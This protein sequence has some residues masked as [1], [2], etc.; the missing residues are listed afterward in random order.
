M[1]SHLILN[2]ALVVGLSVAGVAAQ[3]GAPIDPVTAEDTA[4]KQAARSAQGKLIRGNEL[5][6]APIFDAADEVC[7]E[8]SDALIGSE[9]HVRALLLSVYGVE[10]SLVITPVDIVTPAVE[11]VSDPAVT[12]EIET[13]TMELSSVRDLEELVLTIDAELLRAAPRLNTESRDAPITADRVAAA[14]E[15]FGL[16]VPDALAVTLQPSSDLSPD[17]DTELRMEDTAAELEPA[18]PFCRASKLFGARVSNAEGEDLGELGNLA[19]S[20]GDDRVAYAVLDFGGLLGLGD[21]QFAVPFAALQ[22]HAT[23]A[24]LMLLEVS[25][26]Q[27]EESDGFEQWPAAPD[28]EL[29]PASP[30]ALQ[31]KDV[32]FGERNARR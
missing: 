17:E 24:E 28:T 4:L 29:F 12:D 25:V 26:A 8:V 11:P 3:D 6:G 9:G 20:L 15:H 5:L 13:L 16:E 1:S 31:P 22:A 7:A 19:I 14:Y 23:D 18:T 27:L 32:A 2:S 10:D 21:K 30:R